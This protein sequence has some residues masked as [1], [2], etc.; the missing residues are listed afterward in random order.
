MMGRKLFS[1][2]L[3]ITSPPRQSF[4][5]G[6]RKPHETSRGFDH[7]LSLAAKADKPPPKAF[8]S[9]LTNPLQQTS[10]SN[11]LTNYGN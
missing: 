10:L 8:L 4:I 11:T 3:S 6:D 1:Q 9:F 7:K 5:P 2:H